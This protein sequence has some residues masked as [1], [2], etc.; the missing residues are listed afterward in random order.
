MSTITRYSGD[1]YPIEA[2]LTKDNI[3]VDFSPGEY[4]AKF[5]F[6][7]P[8]YRVVVTGV[9]GND[10]GEVSFPFPADVTAGTYDYD[11]QVTSNAGEIRTF[12]KDKLIII[13]D[14][15]D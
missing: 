11:I 7:K 8:L 3:P 5:S 10:S 9:H 6:S 2:V 12:V 13:D 14:I 1:T 4:T 15:T